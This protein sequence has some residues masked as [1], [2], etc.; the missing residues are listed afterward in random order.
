[1]QRFYC[2]WFHA[3][4]I[5]EKFKYNLWKK[6]GNCQ[7][8]YEGEE[9]FYKSLGIDYEKIQ[10][11]QESKQ[12]LDN[13]K[14][15][16]ES[17]GSRNIIMTTI[18]D[19]DYPERLKSIDTPPIV[20]FL[21]G[22]IE[23]VNWPSI[24]IVGARKCSEYG[25][26]VA[27]ELGNGLEKAGFNVVSGMAL[28]I[29]E[30]AHKGALSQGHHTL[31]VL[32]CGIDICYPKQNSTLYRMLLERG[33]VLSEF[34]PGT[35]PRPYQFPMRNRIIS[36]LSLGVVVVEAAQKSGSLITAHLALE[37][38]REVF[39][40]P[41]N[42]NST[43]SKG[44][45]QLI[46]SGAKMVT[47]VEDIIEELVYQLPIPCDNFENNY[48]NNPTL[49]LDKLEIMVYDNLSWQPTPV[50]DVAQKIHMSEHQIEKILLK[51]EIKGFITRLPGRRYVRLN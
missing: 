1:M 32:G 36:G 46:Q 43:L 51:L 24:A 41:G 31:A 30:A 8:I 20:F 9:D 35:E 18:E 37:Y 44:A 34:L 13:L 5:N 49:I 21:K 47:C 38:N 39:A 26:S 33:A 45:N 29:D 42:I 22:D 4:N 7:K 6:V 10:K 12:R 28:G 11:I 3:L 25:Y 16:Y 15:L 2:L 17:L 50:C 14:E 23:L 19:E 48:T 27:K 40:V